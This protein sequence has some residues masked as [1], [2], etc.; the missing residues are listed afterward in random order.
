MCAII[1]WW[2]KKHENLIFTWGMNGTKGQLSR[3]GYIFLY[4]FF[5][6]ALYVW[7]CINK[8]LNSILFWWL[9]LLMG[10]ILFFLIICLIE[11]LLEKKLKL[12]KF[13]NTI[14][15]L[16][17]YVVC[18]IIIPAELIFGILEIISDINRLRKP[19]YVYCVYAIVY[20]TIYACI[21]LFVISGFRELLPFLKNFEYIWVI[22]NIHVW[23]ILV[24]IS[25]L[26]TFMIRSFLLILL[27]LSSR[28]VFL[29]NTKEVEKLLYV[30]NFALAFL[31]CL[32]ANIVIFDK[33]N[34][35]HQLYYNLT[36]GFNRAF[37]IYIAFDRLCDKFTKNLPFFQ[38]DKVITNINPFTLTK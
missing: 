10:S 17:G 4:F 9:F 34:E 19:I 18:F 15:K 3:V 37:I 12:L 25:F 23:T 31:V 21:F 35:A 1:S 7:Q 20:F 33:K 11:K 14:L 28:K 13:V 36:I 30:L 27:S 5:A 22:G 8:P 16:S 24:L 26:F 2:K 29:E 6:S 32:I 38:K